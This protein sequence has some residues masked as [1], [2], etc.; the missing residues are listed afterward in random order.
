MGALPL[1]TIISPSF[2]QGAFIEGMLLSVRRQSYTNVEHIVVDGGSDDVT[3]DVLSRHTD[4]YNLRWISEP[5]SGMYSAINK[6]L[7]MARGEIVT[8][9]NTDDL[10][11]PWTVATVVDTFLRHPN[12][13]LV[14]GDM[15]SRDLDS[16][17]DKLLF[18]PRRLDVNRLVRSGWLGQPTVFFRRRLLDSIGMFDESLKF[19]GDYDYWIR[20][21]Q[22]CRVAKCREFLAVQTNHPSTKRYQY[23]QELAAEG[24]VLKKKYGAPSGTRLT[25][26]LLRDAVASRLAFTHQMISFATRYLMHRVGGIRPS[27]DFPWSNTITYPGFRISSWVSYLASLVPV[28]GR[29]HQSRAVVFDR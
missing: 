26:W 28:A 24:R 27:A 7:R 15:V 19:L 14:Y 13:E 11:F 2:N 18:F 9:I 21:G 25:L 22:G 3:L 16:G 1:V 20:V 6:G 23:S 12:A 4:A 10:Y 17:R 8:Y 29:E 5:D